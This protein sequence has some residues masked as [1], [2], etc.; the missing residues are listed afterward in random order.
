MAQESECCPNAQVVKLAASI[1]ICFY[2]QSVHFG[3]I[4]SVPLW[5]K[6]FPTCRDSVYVEKAKS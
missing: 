2:S 3:G 5:I 4:G 1:L 6:S